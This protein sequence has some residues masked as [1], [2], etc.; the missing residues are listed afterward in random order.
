MG[1]K[2]SFF[3]QVKVR[4]VSLEKLLYSHSLCRGQVGGPFLIVV[5]G[6]LEWYRV[7]RGRQ[8]FHLRKTQAVGDEAEGDL[9]KRRAEVAPRWWGMSH[10]DSR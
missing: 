9:A 4:Q 3:G 1:K 5:F 2:L 8:S 6:V 7:C 10:L